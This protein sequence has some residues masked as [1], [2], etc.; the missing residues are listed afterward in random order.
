[1]LNT[2][3]LLLT[4]TLIAAC[5]PDLKG[6]DDS[7]DT[8]AQSGCALDLTYSY[9][10]GSDATLTDCADFTLDISFEFDPDEPPLLRNYQIRLFNT[11]D[12][13]FEC[14]VNLT[15]AG[16]CG[17]GYY[18]QTDAGGG[19]VSFATLDCS[20][21]P[22]EHEGIYTAASGYV[23]LKVL[24]TNMDG[25]TGNFSGD[26][27]IVDIAG[28]LA[29]ATTSGI[30]VSGTFSVR[31]EIIGQDAEEADCRVQSSPS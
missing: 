27:L 8:T 10:D 26:P 1:M 11:T 18:H 9:P 19:E 28:D 23:L 17:T 2:R 6:D 31:E 29:V 5:G 4:A 30:T 15:Q 16:V 3:R 13:D 7:G 21:A 24:S 20:G 14:W 22:N 25:T 12:T